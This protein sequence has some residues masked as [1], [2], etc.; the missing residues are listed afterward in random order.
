MRDRC[1]IPFANEIDV[2]IAEMKVDVD[3][4]ILRQKLRQDRR[5]MKHTERDWRGKAYAT[6]RHC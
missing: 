4:W 5:D 3:V 6:T 1:V 2:V